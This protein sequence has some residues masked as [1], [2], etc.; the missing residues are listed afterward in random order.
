MGQ[1]ISDGNIMGLLLVSG[2]SCIRVPVFVFRLPFVVL[3]ILKDILKIFIDLDEVGVSF[4][5]YI[6]CI[7]SLIIIILHNYIA[8]PT[9]PRFFQILCFILSFNT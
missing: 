6:S 2:R 8:L 7:Y 5:F 1:V 4:L 9:F 3:I